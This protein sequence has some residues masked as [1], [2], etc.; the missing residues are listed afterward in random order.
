MR[1]YSTKKETY[2]VF[3]NL[4]GNKRLGVYHGKF[5]ECLDF[6]L[7]IITPPKPNI[8]DLRLEEEARR[9]RRKRGKSNAN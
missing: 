9:K 3:L 4:R 1:D 5:G 2:A 8:E 7:D 6:A